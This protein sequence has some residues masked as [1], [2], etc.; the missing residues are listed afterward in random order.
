MRKVLVTGGTGFI[1]SHLVDRLVG[2]GISVRCLVRETSDLRWLKGLD[3]EFVMGDL[4]D[5]DT[6]EPVVS[7]VDTVFHVAGRTHSSTEEGFYQ[8]NAVGTMN[9][10]KAN[11]QTNPSLFRF[12]YVS[13]L[14]A[15]GPSPDGKSLIE[16]DLPNPLSPYGASKLAGEEAVLAFHPQIPVT[17]IRPPVV[18]GPRDED[19][20]KFFKIIRKGIKPVLGWRY[21]YGSFIFIE[22]LIDGILLA[23]ENK[24]AVGQTYFLVSD[25]RIAYQELNRIIAKTLGKKA[26]TAHVPISFFMAFVVLSEITHKLTKRPVRMDRYR[27]R[28]FRKR[29]WIC[30]GYKARKELG[31]QPTIPLEEGMKKCA[32]WYEKMGWL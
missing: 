13:S 7:N 14:A 1:G 24:K 19:F 20:L 9:L 29:F 32:A 22:D 17:I 4:T 5:Y 2:K 27:I 21:R 18:Y 11:I 26:V 31:F 6:L 15:V 30:D 3:V 12:V 8:T 23:A 28:D 25:N 16:S 10:L